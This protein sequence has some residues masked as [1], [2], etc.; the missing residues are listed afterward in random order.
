MTFGNYVDI[1]ITSVALC[2][3]ETD[4]RSGSMFIDSSII[5]L[6]LTQNDKEQHSN[7]AFV[8]FIIVIRVIRIKK[9]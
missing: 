3:A 2:S 1:S 7:L 4:R 6:M 5:Y 8:T 9:A